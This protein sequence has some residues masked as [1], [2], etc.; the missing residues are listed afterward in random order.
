MNSTID[1]GFKKTKEWKGENNLFGWKGEG[2][3]CTSDDIDWY[4]RYSGG[5]RHYRQSKGYN[6]WALNDEW[7]I[8]INCWLA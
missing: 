5:R 7:K 8:L 2:K 3:L 6:Q 4:T 1:L